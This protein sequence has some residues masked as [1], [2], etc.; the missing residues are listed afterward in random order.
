M[1]LLKFLVAA[2][3]FLAAGPLAMKFLFGG[4]KKYEDEFV[5]VGLPVAP[6]EQGALKFE[7][8]FVCN[9][10]VSC[11]AGLKMGCETFRTFLTQLI[12][13]VST[14]KYHFLIEIARTIWTSVL[15]L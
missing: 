7:V 6:R 8:N 14:S 12:T 3:L 1:T 5:D 2:V 10:F 15:S 11:K 9:A 4:D 13:A